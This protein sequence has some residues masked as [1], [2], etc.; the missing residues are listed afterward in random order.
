[1]R[2]MMPEAY[3]KLADTLDHQAHYRDM[4]DIE[5][6][7]EDGVLYLLQTRGSASALRRR[8]SGSQRR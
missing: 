5:F 6:T 1:M 8:R 3:A 7:V 4:Q 2:E